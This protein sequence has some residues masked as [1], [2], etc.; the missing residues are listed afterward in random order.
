MKC[1]DELPQKEEGSNHKG[2]TELD[3]EALKREA[4]E[5]L[6]EKEKVEDQEKL[7][8]ETKSRRT[9]IEEEKNYQ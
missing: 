8:M 4:Y 7:K 2:L 5:S 3:T 9:V 1:G 6:K